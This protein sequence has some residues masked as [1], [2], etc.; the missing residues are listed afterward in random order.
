MTRP[1]TDPAIRWATP[2]DVPAA[3]RSYA[4][5]GYSGGIA[6]GDVVLVAERDGDV[7]GVVRLVEED[8]HLLLRGMFLDE[9][10]RGRGLGGRMLGRLSD[11]IGERACWLV[12]GRHLARFYGQVGFRPAPEG[13]SPPHLRERAARYAL[14]HG[15]QVI[16]RRDRPS[17]ADL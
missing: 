6:E 5:N 1:S 8:G 12:C 2:E 13:E 7:V 11:A 16:L 4:R 9:A 10:E 3:L 15:P 17:L 14:D